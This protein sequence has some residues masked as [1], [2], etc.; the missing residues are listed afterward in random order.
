MNTW[1]TRKVEGI[2]GAAEKEEKIPA[3]F[4]FA[5]NRT[6]NWNQVLEMSQEMEFGSHTCNHLNL[7]TL[8]EEEVEWE[9]K[10]SRAMIE[11][12]TSGRVLAFSYPAGNCN[13]AM[14][15]MVENSGYRFALTTQKGINSL[16]ETYQL[17]RINIWEDT[18]LGLGGRFFKGF[19]AFKI[20]GY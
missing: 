6:L 14:I 19:F 5:E 10:E 16:K 4:V 3:E 18:A 12:R 13:D 20:L 1:D 7:C 9:I 2:I 11:K 15:K 17:Q 8:P